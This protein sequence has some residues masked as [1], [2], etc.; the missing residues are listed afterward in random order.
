MSETR[1]DFGFERPEVLN[2]FDGQLALGE[3]LRLC[4]CLIRPHNGALCRVD[5]ADIGHAETGGERIAQEVELL[6]INC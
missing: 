3:T 4:V 2:L 1:A 5:L 6:R